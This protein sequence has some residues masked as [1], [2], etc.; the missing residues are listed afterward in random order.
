MELIPIKERLEDNREFTSDPL[1]QASIYATIDYFKKVG[2]EP[3]WISYYVRRNNRLVA[4]AA[5]KGKPVN[6]RV[7]IAYGTFEPY[8][9]QG[10][11][12]QVCKMLVELSLKTDPTVTI[13]A[14]TLPERNFSARILAKNSF[15]FIGIV[16]DP[17]DGDVWEW[18]YKLKKD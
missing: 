14:R 13:T 16:N 7:E 17:E 15:E 12:T 5:F 1:C 6:N 18:E 10:I 3:P 9:Q 4:A 2:Y 8:Q 11:G